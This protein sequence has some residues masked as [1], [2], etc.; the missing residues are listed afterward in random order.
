MIGIR[1]E[2][3]PDHISKSHPSSSPSIHFHGFQHPKSKMEV[4]P[5]SQ[6]IPWREGENRLQ[7]GMM[8]AKEN[9]PTWCQ[10]IK[11]W[12]ESFKH[13]QEEE[14]RHMAFLQV[15]CAGECLPFALLPTPFLFTSSCLLYALEG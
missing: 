14:L 5:H 13:E 12:T 3:N 4:T 1:G 10:S 9:Q 15:F 11:I 8:S 6:N 7:L 2:Q